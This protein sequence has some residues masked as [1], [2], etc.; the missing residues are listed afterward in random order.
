MAV[1]CASP[2]VQATNYF[3]TED[4]GGTL[5]DNT[6]PV[7]PITDGD[8][9]T[10]NGGTYGSTVNE[11]A[12]TLER[13]GT[14]IIN[15]GIPVTTNTGG[16]ENVIE[17]SN[18]GAGTS[19]TTITVN[20]NPSRNA[21]GDF[22]DL[23]TITAGGNFVV[24]I[25]NGAIVTG[26]L[27]FSGNA[28]DN[29]TYNISSAT[30][31][32]TSNLQSGSL[33]IG[34]TGDSGV[35]AITGASAASI[36]LAIDDTTSGASL[37][38]LTGN[39]SAASLNI[40]A[41]NAATATIAS[42]TDFN[43]LNLAS[44]GSELTVTNAIALA[45][46]NSGTIDLVD[47]T[48][49][50]AATLD[51]DYTITLPATVTNGASLHV[52]G[53]AG[54]TTSLG[55]LIVGQASATFDANLAVEDIT[56]VESSDLNVTG[57]LTVNNFTVDAGDVD[58]TGNLTVSSD[59]TMDAGD[60]DV[61]GNLTANNFTVDAGD[62]DVTGNL[63]VSTD[64]TM[65]GGAVAIAGNIATSA[66]SFNLN[67]GTF[68]ASGASASDIDGVLTID[69]ANASFTQADFAQAA[70]IDSGSLTI[71]GSTSNI[72]GITANGGNVVLQGTT[73][74]NTND[75]IDITAGTLS[76]ES[77]TVNLGDQQLIASGTGSI[78][79][80]NGI[81]I[82]GGGGGSASI[83]NSNSL[84]LTNNTINN[85]TLN[86][87]AGIS[88]IN[89]AVG[90]GNFDLDI[91]GGSVDIADNSTLTL[92]NLTQ[93]GGTLNIIGSTINAVSNSISGGSININPSATTSI[94]AQ[95]LTL[96]ANTTLNI[97]SDLSV[98]ASISGDLSFAGEVNLNA[99]LTI[100]G[101]LINNGGTLTVPAGTWTLDATNYTDAGSAVHAAEINGLN[102][103]SSLIVNGDIN[104]DNTELQLSLNTTNLE[105]REFV[106]ISAVNVTNGPASFDLPATFGVY[107]LTSD[108]T[109][110]EV[111]V[112][113]ER[114]VNYSNFTNFK[115]SKA[116]GRALSSI[117]L[118]NTTYTALTDAEKQMF[119]SVDSLVLASEDI[120]R[121]LGQF[122]S[123]ASESAVKIDLMREVGYTVDQ[124]LAYL[125]SDKDYVAASMNQDAHLWLRPVFIH[126]LRKPTDDYAGF[127]VSTY[128]FAVG[129]DAQLYPGQNFGLAF[130]YFGSE[131][132]ER[133]NDSSLTRAHSYHFMPYG[134]YDL[135]FW[136]QKYGEIDWLL[137]YTR[138]NTDSIRNISIPGFNDVAVAVIESNQYTIRF[139]YTNMFKLNEEFSISPISSVMF[140]H[141]SPKEYAETGGPARL[142]VSSDN[143]NLLE[144]GLGAK[145]LH[146]ATQMQDFNLRTEFRALALWAPIHNAL[147]TTSSFQVGGQTFVTS[148]EQAH[149]A[150]RLGCSFIINY[151]PNVDFELSYDFEYKNNYFEHNAVLEFKLLF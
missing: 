33:T 131:S 70:T 53:N 10:F 115:N 137:S 142:N 46:G 23:S 105:P 116:V 130:A 147:Q 135:L 58:V 107:S 148:V 118:E 4:N 66:G 150:G 48:N 84:S 87:T 90:S 114:T 72:A 12:I 20:G 26:D 141:L 57:N 71:N 59:F 91:S 123:K 83:D 85:C 49:L 42:I 34:V 98:A 69:G 9:L 1:L 74:N 60:V 109:D 19:A 144:F 132:K 63:I 11:D 68:T 96:G 81:T 93:S 126:G 36:S 67:A 56:L 136:G 29:T 113:L 108:V 89:G 92:G 65:E 21:S 124:R 143:L 101:D 95:A 125:R 102:S 145:L 111:K 2:N 16:G 88:S 38:A 121:Q 106:L 14:I 94:F 119:L 13:G 99:D 40:G 97:N 54:T 151:L 47:G 75:N 73:L 45:N 7:T 31:N 117:S 133:L 50:T 103:F 62:V 25:G 41:T 77:T 8:I 139:G 128:G 138:H 32:G 146:T 44:N 64:F 110:T 30:I 112:T 37:G 78:T 17:G 149:W 39:N 52:T 82:N 127:K 140:T 24:T 61:T 100:D 122:V 129:V 86:N 43:N 6:G 18:N 79:V 80:A 55:N 104:L 51:G 5:F 35:G 28:T 27:T 76:L 120:D 22:L 134:T 15:S 3:Y